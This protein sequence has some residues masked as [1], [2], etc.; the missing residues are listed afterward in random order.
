M[1]MRILMLCVILFSTILFAQEEVK[2]KDGRTII[3]NNNGTWKYKK[4]ST[5]TNEV[6]RRIVDQMVKDDQLQQSCID[7]AGGIKNAIDIKSVSLSPNG[8]QYL[9]FG[10]SCGFGA[11][12]PIYWVY[13]NRNGIIKMLGILGATDN[14]KITTQ[15]T[16]GYY[17][18]QISSYYGG[19]N[20][21]HTFRF[22]FNGNEYKQVGEE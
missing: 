3:I 10:G 4:E 16:N 11:R 21:F 5:A 6:K 9:L 13:E 17:D 8:E 18:I 7:E 15:R 1:K 12:T 19:D 22:K 14:V 2:R 20:S